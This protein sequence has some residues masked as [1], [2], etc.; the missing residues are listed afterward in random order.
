[1]IPRPPN[2]PLISMFFL[3][4]SKHSR[5]DHGSKRVQADSDSPVVLAPFFRGSKEMLFAGVE[6][7]CGADVHAWTAVDF[8]AP[9][10]VAHAAVERCFVVGFGGIW[11]NGWRCWGWEGCC[12]YGLRDGEEGK[13]EGK[14]V[15]NHSWMGLEYRYGLQPASYIHFDC[16]SGM[17]NL[18]MGEW[19]LQFFGWGSWKW[20]NGSISEGRW[21]LAVGQN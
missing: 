14:E 17:W 7:V 15:E 18:L 13:K 12:I 9:G 3:R 6:V 21:D 4:D 19:D 10:C 1:M 20:F 8:S 16:N 2:T 11:G 5:R